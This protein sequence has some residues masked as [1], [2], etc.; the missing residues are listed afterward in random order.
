MDAQGEIHELNDENRLRIAHC[1]DFHQNSVWSDFQ[2][3]CFK[4]K[5]V[6]PFK[7]IFRELYVPTPDELQE[8]SISR[9]YAGNQIQPKQALT[10]LKTRG[11]Q[12]DYDEG[13][14]KVNHHEGFQNFTRRGCLDCAC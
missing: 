1:T 3:Y 12:V 4:E 11:W 14:R 7:Q 9:R 6:Q 10:L 2:H 5:T 8:K 13:L